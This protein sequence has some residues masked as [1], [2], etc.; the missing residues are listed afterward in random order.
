MKLVLVG[1]G[2]SN[3]LALSR[4]PAD[5][6]PLL[7]SESS[8]TAYSGLLPGAIAGYHRRQHC[9]IDLP[10]TMARY[11]GDFLVGRAVGIADRQLHLADGRT[12]PF[13]LL[14]VN[15]GARQNPLFAAPDSCTVKPIESFLQFL[16]GVRLTRGAPVAVIGAGAG[17][18]ETAMA[19]H[20]RWAASAPAVT[21]IGRQF[22]PE[23]PPAMRRRVAT[24]LAARAIT[25]CQGEAVAAESGAVLL[26]D[27]RRVAAEQI[28]FAADVVAPP[29]LRNTPLALDENGF[30]RVNEQLQSVNNDNIF[31]CGD[32]A[33][34]PNSL[35]KSGVMAVRQGAVLG[36]NLRIALEQRQ[37]RLRRWRA[38]R[39]ALYI[40]G[41]ADGS[42]IGCRNNI[43]FAGRWV[44]HWKN[45][46]DKR[47]MQRF[48]TV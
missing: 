20:K 3:L 16:D 30:A 11:R 19:L 21:L 24:R 27:G 10:K 1:G 26:S 37:P 32:A 29:W 18:V 41:C 17:G 28:I 38:Q 6:R 48:H 14:A 8:V 12:V 47:F 15:C 25:V 42:A 31:I 13:D 44:W 2:H 43:S 9:F 36:D 40:I 4:L 7:V 33:A 5:C 39:R 45:Y 23:F 35:P 22:L 46:L 34:H